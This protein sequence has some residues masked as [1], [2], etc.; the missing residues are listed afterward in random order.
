MIL[1]PPGGPSKILKSKSSLPIAFKFGDKVKLEWR[2]VFNIKKKY[3][4]EEYPS[5]PLGTDVGFWEFILKEMGHSKNKSSFL[6]KIFFEKIFF[7][8]KIMF[9]D[10]V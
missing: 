6:R 7:R 8:T 2:S 5:S 10:I 4:D 9:E 3:K 1:G